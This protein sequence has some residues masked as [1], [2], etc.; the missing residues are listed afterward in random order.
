MSVPSASVTAPGMSAG[1]PA[2]PCTAKSTFTGKALP[3]ASGTHTL[4][5]KSARSLPLGPRPSSA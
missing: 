4:P 3:P 2:P 5:A 1:S